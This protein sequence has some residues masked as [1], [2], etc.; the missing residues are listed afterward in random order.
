MSTRSF[1][2]RKTAD[3]KYDWA[4]CHFDGYVAGVGKTL[5]ENY[6]DTDKIKEL[7][8]GG[9]MSILGARINPTNPENHKFGYTKNEKTGEYINNYEEGVTLYYHRDRGES[10]ESTI[11]EPEADF[12]T[13]L[14]D[15][16]IDY[17]YLWDGKEW[18]VWGGSCNWKGGYPLSRAV[19]E[20]KK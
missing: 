5:Y 20:L 17:V 4:Y 19:A 9:D 16:G 18:L 2:V 13:F 10:A 14:M 11:H 3:N 12:A 6:T 1:I 15:Y 7:L 8:S